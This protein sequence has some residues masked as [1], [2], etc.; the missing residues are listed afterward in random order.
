MSV[1]YLES[2][3]LCNIL[4]TG[5]VGLLLCKERAFL[6]M[7]IVLDANAGVCVCVC[8]SVS[9]CVRV[10]LY[11]CVCVCVHLRVQVHAPRVSRS[12]CTASSGSP[13]NAASAR[14]AAHQFFLSPASGGPDTGVPN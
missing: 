4:T 14:N 8:V 12:S 2:Y 10:S 13:L 11:V 3:R 1:S 9:V 5:R 6:G 7:H